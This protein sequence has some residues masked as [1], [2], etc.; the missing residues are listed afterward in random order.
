[1]TRVEMTQV[2]KD[3]DQVNTCVR[4]SPRLMQTAS[5]RQLRRVRP[6]ILKDAKLSKRQS[7]LPFIWSFDPD[8]QRRAAAWYFANMV[9]DNSPGG[10]YKRTGKTDKATKVTGEFTETGGSVTLANERQ[11]SEFVLGARQVPGHARAGHPTLM[12]VAEK[13]SPLLQERFSETW[14]TVADPF[15]GVPR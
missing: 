4:S 12:R 7:P 2:F 1:M 10:R 3:L 14:L 11:G 9:D 5:D 8:A 15:A 6:L 13:W